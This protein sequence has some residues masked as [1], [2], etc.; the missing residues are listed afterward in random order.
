MAHRKYLLNSSLI[1]THIRVIAPPCHI[2][3]TD[4]Q[5]YFHLPCSSLY[6]K[7]WKPGNSIFQ[8]PLSSRFQLDFAMAEWRGS[9]YSLMAGTWGSTDAGSKHRILLH[10]QSSTWELFSP[11]LQAAEIIGGSFAVILV[12]RQKEF[13]RE[14]TQRESYNQ[15]YAGK[16][17]T[18]GCLI[19]RVCPFPQCKWP[20][21]SWHQWMV[22]SGL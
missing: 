10:F 4:I 2:G 14:I 5:Y 3:F 13:E 20:I 8:I 1:F 15:W 19:C 6:Q 7:D 12:L 22:K 9:Y 17:L 18:T 11:V 16:C 21:S